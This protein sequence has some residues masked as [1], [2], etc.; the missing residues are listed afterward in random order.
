MSLEMADSSWDG[1]VTQVGQRG[2]TVVRF[3][4]VPKENET[5]SAQLGR[6]VF[7]DVEYI[8]IRTPGDLTNIPFRPVTARDKLEFAH[9]YNAWKQGLADPAQGT[10]LSKWPGCTRSQ[11]EELAFYAVRTVEDLASVSDGNIQ[12]LPLGTT[13]LKQRAIDFLKS[14]EGMS[15]ASSLRADLEKE[16]LRTQALERTVKELGDKLEASRKKAG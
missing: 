4:L 9:A 13:A 1:A 5:K 7:E 11:V 8:E 14:A 15:H 2:R 10:P 6:P 12:K 3:E 16:K